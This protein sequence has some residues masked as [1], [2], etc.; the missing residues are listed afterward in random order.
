MTPS[1]DIIATLTAAGQFKTLLKALDAT[2]LTSVLKGKGPLTLFAP[3]DAAFAAMPP[4]QLAALMGASPP[5]DLQK[6]LIYHIINAKVDDSKI[7]GRAR[8]RPWPR[9]RSMSTARARP[10]VAPTSP[11]DRCRGDQQR[12]LS[13]RQGAFPDLHPAAGR[14]GRAAPRRACGHRRQN[15]G[16]QEEMESLCATASLLERERGTAVEAIVGG[17][18]VR[19]LFWAPGLFTETRQSPKTPRKRRSISFRI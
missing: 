5:A 6:L 9:P 14:Q 11:R 13:D 3:T 12:R 15:R 17:P 10:V 2:N 4:G 7:K 19:R 1:G 16:P 8:S 18:M